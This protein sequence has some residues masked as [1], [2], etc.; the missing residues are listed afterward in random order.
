M[1]WPN[2]LYTDSRKDTEGATRIAAVKRI[3]FVDVQ[4][5]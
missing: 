5:E 4:K 3:A 2:L 1:N